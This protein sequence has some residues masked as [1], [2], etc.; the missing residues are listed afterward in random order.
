MTTTAH[1]PAAP[2]AAR[3][4]ALAS[5]RLWFGADA[6]VTGGN[7]V[8]Y[9]AVAGPLADL[10][11]GGAGT[12]RGI[13]AFLLAYAAGVALYARSPRSTRTGWA[14]V[15]TNAV[16]VIASVDVAV[17]GAFDLD[18]IGRCWVVAQALVV[19]AFVL[20]QARVL[21]ARLLA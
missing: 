4:A 14:I 9:L 16:W 3:P 7:A 18:P 6:V 5:R 10:L 17:T 19:A 8:A 1:R 2:T 15:A 12:W 20:L 21:R 11:G 13:G